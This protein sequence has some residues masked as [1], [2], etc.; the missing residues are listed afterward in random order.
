MPT[1]TW[2][3]RA[4]G[5]DDVVRGHE[6]IRQSEERL[7]RSR[8]RGAGGAGGTYNR[9][10]S[11]PRGKSPEEK[12]AEQAARTKIKAAEA[13]TRAEQREVDRR[14][15][16]ERKQR[17]AHFVE[18]HRAKQRE[19]KDAAKLTAQ[20]AAIEH[21]ELEKHERESQ[22]RREKRWA[23]AKG[24]ASSAG[25]GIA[26]GVAA[27]GIAAGAA[28]TGV[29]AASVRD[30][31]AARGRA[32][33]L[34]VA[35]RG[36]GEQAVSPDLILADATKTALGVKGTKTA[37]VLASMQKYV[38]MT[39]DLAGARGN[40]KTFAVAAR[41]TGSTEEEIAATAATMREK[42][43]ITDPEQMRDALARMTFQGKSGAFEMKDA[44][45]FFTEM[46]ASGARFGLDKG[47]G[48]VATLGGLAQ[49]AMKS[50]GSGAKASTGVQAMLRQ[51]VAKG[52]AGKES[53]KALTGAEVFTDKTHTKTRNVNDVLVDV[54]K[55]AGGDQTKLQKIFG[56]EG[57]VGASELIKTFNEAA[58]A[59]KKGAT[60]TERRAAGEAAL[61]RLLDQTINA[62]GD[63]AEVQ[64]DAAAAT[65]TASAQLTTAWETASASVGDALLPA[66]TKI[67]TAVAPLAASLK[68]FAEGLA[69]VTDRVVG[70]AKK[71]GWVE[72][73]AAEQGSSTPGFDLYETSQELS[74]LS[75]KEKTLGGLSSKD[76]QRKAELQ[77]KQLDLKD[78]LLAENPWIDLG[79]EGGFNLSEDPKA[80]FEAIMGGLH[81]DADYVQREKTKGLPHATTMADEAQSASVFGKAMLGTGMM[82][83][84]ITSGNS[85]FH[86]PD[87]A[88]R[89][90]GAARDARASAA[91]IDPSGSA[92]ADGGANATKDAAGATKDAAR[93]LIIAAER[94]MP[95][96]PGNP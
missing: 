60:E 51:L 36:A 81:E 61:R 94:L 48:G 24:M 77:S 14:I 67:V 12:A 18:Q 50:A 47:V 4:E 46:G 89:E 63:W 76:L 87:Q 17:Q 2:Q 79:E 6:R 34:S 25:W 10:G 43:G 40:A 82:L 62:G 39:G 33:A 58:N 90:E 80:G 56:D 65:D 11:A 75:E 72:E 22:R 23:S 35:G 68:P 19:A 73:P 96:I 54:I 49:I 71:M 92:P 52:G 78:Q 20:M 21:R 15:N 69:I 83:D 31:E 66:F 16:Y 37:D 57:M 88:A 5:V 95:K 70:L 27:A 29:A 44:S 8:S 45:Q 93:A 1:R 38:Q 26:G 84:N 91:R 9:S 28:F 86:D 64:K 74:A 32:V 42:F 30:R 41:A 13:A 53:I 7:G 55:G 59:T 3:F 85:L